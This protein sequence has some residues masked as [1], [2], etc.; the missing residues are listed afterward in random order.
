[1]QTTAKP[2]SS[3]IELLLHNVTWAFENSDPTFAE[4]LQKAV[5]AIGPEIALQ[6]DLTEPTTP[7]LQKGS[8]ASQPEIHLH[9][10]FLELL[11]ASIYGWMVIYE[12][13]IQRPMLN[14]TYDGLMKFETPLL[15]RANQLVMW[16]KDMK[17]NYT[18]WPLHLP[19]PDRYACEREEFYGGRANRV[20]Q[21]AA[22]FLLVHEFAHARNDHLEVASAIV[23]EAGRL[24]RLELEKEADNFAFEVLIPQDADDHEKLSKGWAILGLALTS[25]YLIR[26]IGDIFQQTHPAL[27]HRLEHLRRRLDFQE[28]KHQ[29]Y[30]DYLCSTFLGILLDEAGLT[31]RPQIY[32]TANDA[33]QDKLDRLDQYLN[34]IYG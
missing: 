5:G 25:F 8:K 16:A 21:E 30:F 27:H 22:S 28:E 6:M 20:F 10:T 23:G 14:G 11:W 4:R 7:F 13:G 24:L 19:A 1:M 12:E 18:P 31:D 17:K 29:F 15:Q 26:D 33:L 2:N 32:D 34:E 9:I 3:P